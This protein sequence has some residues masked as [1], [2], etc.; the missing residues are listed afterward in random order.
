MLRLEENKMKRL[1]DKRILPSSKVAG[2]VEFRSRS[3][4]ASQDLLSGEFL[5]ISS[6]P[7]KGHGFTILEKRRQIPGKLDLIR[8]EVTASSQNRGETPVKK[9]KICS[10]Q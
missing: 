3:A 9:S 10:K 7:A 8:V 5:R 1:E 6:L 4:D 2:S